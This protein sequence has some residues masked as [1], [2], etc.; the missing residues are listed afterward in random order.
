M[1]P[2]LQEI[3]R[4]GIRV[5][6]PSFRKVPHHISEMTIEPWNNPNV[7]D[8]T[9]KTDAINGLLWSPPK[10]NWERSQCHRKNLAFRSK[11]WRANLIQEFSTHPNKSVWI[12]WYSLFLPCTIAW[13][14]TC[15]RELP[16]L[17]FQH[18]FPRH[19]YRLYFVVIGDWPRPHG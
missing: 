11:T 9:L 3:V 10:M 12:P 1:H 6:Q 4:I 16:E 15:S 14:W 17:L 18:K 8:R 7:D 5:L 2:K 13:H 19:W